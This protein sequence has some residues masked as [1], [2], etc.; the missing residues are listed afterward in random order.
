MTVWRTKKFVST[1]KLKYFIRVIVQF[2]V[3]RDYNRLRRLHLSGDKCNYCTMDS[4]TV[5]SRNDGIQKET[6]VPLTKARVSPFRTYI[7]FKL[8][9]R[10]KKLVTSGPKFKLVWNCLLDFFYNLR[11]DVKKSPMGLPYVGQQGSSTVEVCV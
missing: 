10:H 6:S 2:S 9:G 5:Q 3:F 11:R 7:S 8:R 4:W 1:V